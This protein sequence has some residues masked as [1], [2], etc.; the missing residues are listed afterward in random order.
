MRWRA[1]LRG[2]A[3]IVVWVAALAGLIAIDPGSGLVYAI[4][5]TLLTVAVGA[6]LDTFWVLLV[7]LALGA[8]VIVPAFLASGDCYSCGEDA[9]WALATWI[10]ILL[11]VVPA[12][13]A[14]GVG[15]VARRV[16]R[17]LRPAA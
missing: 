13:V 10:V 6:L 2:A 11:F 15:V 4:G 7:P 5:G 16:A 3:V 12:T 17:S 8:L 14:L 9:S 1:L